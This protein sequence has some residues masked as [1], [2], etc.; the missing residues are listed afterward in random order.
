MDRLVQFLRDAAIFGRQIEEG[1]G[2]F[3]LSRHLGGV[4]SLSDLSRADLWRTLRGD[5]CHDMAGR[6][7]ARDHGPRPDQRPFTDCNPTQ[8]HCTRPNRSPS[9]DAGGDD[10]PIGF[11]L[12]MPVARR[13]HADSGH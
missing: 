1:N 13:R 9:A 12:Q 3:G 6:H 11:C 2:Q 7:V 5:A 4:A 10:L 8:N